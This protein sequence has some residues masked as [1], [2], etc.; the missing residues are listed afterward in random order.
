MIEQAYM[1]RPYDPIT[2]FF[3]WATVLLIVAQFVL[4]WI[5]P[6][7]HR[8]THP[9]GLIGWHLSIGAALVLVVVLRVLWRFTHQPLPDHDA[10]WLHLISRVTHF[11]L[12]VVLVITPFLGWANASSRGWSIRAFGSVPLPPLAQ[13]GS[14]VGHFMGDVHGVMAWVLFALI[15]LH[16]LAAIFHHLVLKDGTLKKMAPW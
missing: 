12:Y 11:L 4:G 6:D 3:H 9:D 10:S 5:M 14:S 2:R 8:D 13:Q 16:V 15:C 1:Y 7:V